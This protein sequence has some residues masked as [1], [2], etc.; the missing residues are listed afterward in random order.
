MLSG[1]A[2]TVLSI[3]TLRQIYSMIYGPVIL[4]DKDGGVW[5]PIYLCRKAD[6][7]L[8]DS[9]QPYVQEKCLQFKCAVI[10]WR[11]RSYYRSSSR[12]GLYYDE[13][14]RGNDEREQHTSEMG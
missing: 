6:K 5:F 12:G 11:Q 8:P 9:L 10:P 13:Q 4:D 2:Y 14:T 3:A 1:V 7:D